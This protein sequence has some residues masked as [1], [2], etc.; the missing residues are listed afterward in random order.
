LSQ[1]HW[2]AFLMSMREKV[3]TKVITKWIF[4]YYFSIFN[5]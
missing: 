5:L 2:L 3:A 4:K 1:E